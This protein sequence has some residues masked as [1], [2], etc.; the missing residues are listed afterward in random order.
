MLTQSLTHA[1]RSLLNRR[2]FLRF[3]G[4]GLGGIALTTLLAEEGLLG[5]DRSP[6]RPQGSPQ[7]PLAPRP[8]HFAAKAKNVPVLFCSAP[9]KHLDTREYKPQRRKPR[10]H[11]TP[12]SR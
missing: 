7:N 3:A 5:A 4:T 6:I 8:P 1:G 12:C 9:C 11:T 10:A 2:A